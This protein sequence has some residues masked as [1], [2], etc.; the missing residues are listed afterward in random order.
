MVQGSAAAGGTKGQETGLLG[1]LH[2]VRD[3]IWPAVQGCLI[4]LGEIALF[5]LELGLLALLALL[6]VQAL[7][8][9]LAALIPSLT[10]LIDRGRETGS[11]LWR[12]GLGLLRE[13]L[14]VNPARRRARHARWPRAGEEDGDLGSGLILALLDLICLPI[15]WLASLGFQRLLRPDPATEEKEQ[16]RHH[17]PGNLMARLGWVW[18]RHVTIDLLLSVLRLLFPRLWLPG[19]AWRQMVNADSYAPAFPIRGMLWLSLN[20]DVR[21]VLGRP[22]TFEVIYGPRMQSVTRPV[23]LP[24]DEELG[25]DPGERGNFL[26]GMQDTPRYWRDISNMRLAFRREDSERCRRLAEEAAASALQGAIREHQQGRSASGPM[27]LDLPVQLILPAVEALINRYFGLPVPLRCPTAQPGGEGEGMPTELVDHGHAWLEAVFNHLFYD[28]KGEVSR[29]ACME[30]APRVRQAL[31]AIIERAHDRTDPAAD[32]VLNRCLRLQ[33]SGTPGMDDETLRINLTGF[34]VGAVTPLFNA[35]CQALDVL[36]ERPKAL[37]LAQAAARRNDIAGVRACLMEALR[38]QAGDP[39]IY[40]WTRAD[41][42]IG[43]GSR[44]CSIPRGTLVMAWNASA[45][46]DPAAMRAPWA[47]RSDRPADAYLHWGHGQHSCAGAYINMAVIPGVLTP[48]LRQR[49][50]RRAPGPG[51]QMR[52]DANGGITVRHFELQVWPSAEADT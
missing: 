26:L 11:R 37:A 9:L 52:K 8:R 47:F 10:V 36:L 49:R 12:L 22:E 50:L 28:L 38:F 27:V 25:S 3:L 42:W 33:E 44:R 13:L 17:E 46:F 21:E 40:R 35:T 43:A 6:L 14:W 39:V 51:G 45:M 2:H 31:I 32:T 34:L 18:A 1:V 15:D 19:V 29:K 30:A 24:P 7:L 20:G 48:L 4:R 23:D 5:L 41:T 16:R